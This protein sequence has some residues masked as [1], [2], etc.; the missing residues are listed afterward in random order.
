MFGLLLDV[1]LLATDTS[2]V[3]M[4]A[5]G[6][7]GYMTATVLSLSAFLILKPAGA[8]RFWR[9]AAVSLL[10]VNLVIFVVGVYSFSLTGYGGPR[11][12][13]I[14]FLILLASVVFFGLRRKRGMVE[15]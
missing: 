13:I 4:V 15:D 1:V 3:G 11:E 9:L 10:V 2:P 14:G 8:G 12:A 7:I 6:T 5:T